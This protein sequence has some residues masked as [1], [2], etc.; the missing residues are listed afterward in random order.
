[1]LLACDYN[2]GRF[3]SLAQCLFCE[4]IRIELGPSLD[5]PDRKERQ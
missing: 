3:Y 1:M 2:W 4:D 5:G